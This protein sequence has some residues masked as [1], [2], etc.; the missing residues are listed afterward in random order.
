MNGLAFQITEDDVQIVLATMGVESTSENIES[1]FD[2]LDYGRIEKDALSATDFD[3]QVNLAHLS[4][5]EQICEAQ[6][7]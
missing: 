5:K 4:I 2:E 7:F 6:I 1:A 3:E